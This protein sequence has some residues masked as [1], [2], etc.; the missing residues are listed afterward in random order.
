ML[1][2]DRLIVA[3]CRRINLGNCK[4]QVWVMYV[5]KQTPPHANKPEK[6]DHQA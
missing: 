1:I 2:V 6:L 5:G 4:W 3:A